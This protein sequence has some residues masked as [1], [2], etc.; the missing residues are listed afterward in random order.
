MFSRLTFAAGNCHKLTVAES[1][2]F[3]ESAMR[4]WRRTTQTTY[5]HAVESHQA[6]MTDGEVLAKFSLM[7]PNTIV[8]LHRLNLF[9]R[10]ATGSN[11]I[12]KAV[13]FAAGNSQKS[14]LS[15]VKED[16]SWLTKL[17]ATADEP[18]LRSVKSLGN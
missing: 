10:V 12:V 1:K 9:V 5:R 7:A 8:T 16:F 11:L 14:W 4:V 18:C 15:A 6:P 2:K 17:N 13:A 3:T